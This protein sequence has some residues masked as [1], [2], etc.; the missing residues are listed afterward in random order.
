[1][2]EFHKPRCYQAPAKELDGVAINVGKRCFGIAEHPGHDGPTGHAG[3][4]VDLIEHVE[5]FEPAQGAEVKCNGARPAAGERQSDRLAERRDGRRSGDPAA[6]RK[7]QFGSGIERSEF[8]FLEC[9]G[10][11]F[12]LRACR[13]A[14]DRHQLMGAVIGGH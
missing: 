9:L 6:D 5:V 2:E 7:G 3:D 12:R 1:M 11:E 13:V 10:S 4:Y 14:D 8:L